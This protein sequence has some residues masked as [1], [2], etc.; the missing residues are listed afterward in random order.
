MVNAI[1]AVL[2]FSDSEAEK[3]IKS[4]SQGK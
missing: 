3:A 4:L 2:K 1:A